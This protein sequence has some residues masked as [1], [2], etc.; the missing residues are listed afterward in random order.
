M[1]TLTTLFSAFLVLA[2]LAALG[3]G[4]YLAVSW[5]ADGLSKLD[6]Q[7]ATPTAITSLVIL[8]A[9]MIIASSIRRASRQ[10][11][12]TTLQ[13]EKAATYQFFIDVWRTLLQ[14]GREPEE[15]GSIELLEERQALDHLLAL[16]GSPSVVKAHIALRT[17]ERELGPRSAAVRSQFTGTLLEIRKDLG[18]DTQGLIVEEL[19]QL[20]FADTNK[21]SALAKVSA[22]QDLA[23]HI[24][25]APDS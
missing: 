13:A 1:K 9:T 7:L 18:S 19:Q 25:L 4:G 14:H 10:H 23:P 8:L 16:Y 15:P 11:K 24:S 22:H 21:A 3:F 6:V 17:L 5:A 2:F 20:F 12:A